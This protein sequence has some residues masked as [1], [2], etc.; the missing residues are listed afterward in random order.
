MSELRQDPLTGRWVIL[1]AGR[2]RRPDEFGALQRG[3]G[4]ADEC[5]F[6]PG[7]EDR[8][9][10]EVLVRGRPDGAPADGPGWRIRVFPNLYPALKARRGAGPAPAAPDGADEADLLRGGPGIGAHEV[11]VYSPDHAAGPAALGAAGWG[12]LLLV[13]RERQAALAE[14]PD[15]RYVLPFL[16]H[17]PEAGATRSHPH[18]QL[19]A[20]PV[21]PDL[22]ALKQR[23]LADHRARTGRCLVCDLLAAERAAG[24]RLLGE[25]EHWTALAPWAS[26]FPWQVQLLPRR[27]QAALTD[28]A[29][30]E[31]G[32]LAAALDRV[33]RGLEDLRPG[34]SLNLYLHGAP[35][36]DE[37]PADFHWHLEILPRLGRLAGFE[38]GTGFAINPVAPETA[39]GRLRW[40][41]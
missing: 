2:G 1:A 36:G 27:H 9:T 21:V 7:R 23:R 18:L 4:L 22:V 8:T 38:Q 3:G 12:E 13:L 33:L 35:L 29:D 16:N 40:K 19:I 34:L 17:G 24:R 15:H 28:A 6:C 20:T 30:E 11:V 31:L 32:A 5:P 41:E 26:L 37:P 10:P 39:A 14:V 25:N